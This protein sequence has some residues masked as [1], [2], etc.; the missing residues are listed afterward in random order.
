MGTAW[1]SHGFFIS[2]GNAA[3]DLI[4]GRKKG[5]DR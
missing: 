5:M 1:C 4:I 3:G 2:A